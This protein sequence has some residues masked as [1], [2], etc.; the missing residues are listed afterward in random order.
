MVTAGCLGYGPIH[1]LAASAVAVGFRWDSRVLGWDRPGLLALSN[2]ACAALCLLFLVLGRIRL[3]LVC[4]LGKG[5]VVGHCLTC[6]VRCS[7]TLAMFGREI[8]RSVPVGGLWNGILLARATDQPVPRRFCG[9]FDGDGHLSW[10]CTFLPLVEIR[11]NPEFHDLMSMDKGH[12]GVSA[13]LVVW[14]S[15]CFSLG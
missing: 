9:G 7:L 10:E 15:W 11:E 6:P 14:Y 5:F 1:L 4:V 13:S 8:L 12:S 2:L 3:L